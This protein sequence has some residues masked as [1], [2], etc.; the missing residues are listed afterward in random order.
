MS[1]PPQPAKTILVVD[2]DSALRDAVCEL[3]QSGGYDVVPAQKGLEALQVCQT[4]PRR[5]DLVILDIA[6]PLMGGVD[7]AG[8]MRRKRPLRVLFMSGDPSLFEVH[9]ARRPHD[10]A[11]IQKPFTRDELLLTVRQVLG[12][13]A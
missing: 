8:R 7:L 9:N 3:L 2:D 12:A 10:A 4:L 13:D 1:F 11:F 6:M 5:L